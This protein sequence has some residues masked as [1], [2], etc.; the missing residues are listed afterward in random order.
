MDK[1]DIAP[2]IL[3]Q[4]NALVD[5]FQQHTSLY[6][7]KGGGMRGNAKQIA[8][9]YYNDMMRELE[10]VTGHSDSIEVDSYITKRVDYFQD[11]I[12]AI[13]ST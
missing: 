6:D 7:G 9:M 3:H 4:A 2:E 8:I 13:K 11:L 12:T 5:K 1:T 10:N